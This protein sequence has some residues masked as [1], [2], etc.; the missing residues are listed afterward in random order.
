MRR[1]KRR[2]RRRKRRRRMRS[3]DIGSCSRMSSLLMTRIYVG[4]PC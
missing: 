3:T 1:R 4:R 2:R